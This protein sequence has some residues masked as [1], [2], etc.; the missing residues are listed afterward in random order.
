MTEPDVDLELYRLCGL[1]RFIERELTDD[2]IRPV[3]EE[4]RYRW[5]DM[6]SPS[7]GALMQL[8]IDLHGVDLDQVERV[9]AEVWGR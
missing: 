8:S 6:R 7:L 5:G 1:E 4:V 3:I 9:V 2:D